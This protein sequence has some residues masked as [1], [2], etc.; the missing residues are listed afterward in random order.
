MHSHLN[1]QRHRWEPSY[2][3]NDDD[4]DEYEEEEKRRSSFE[5]QR[6]RPS[7]STA[8]TS[9]TATH[10]YPLYEEPSSYTS[11]Y[12]AEEDEDLYEHAPL[13]EKEWP[14]STRTRSPRHR[15]LRDNINEKTE[16]S[17]EDPESRGEDWTPSCTDSLRRQWQAIALS[18]RFSLFRT[19]RRLRRRLTR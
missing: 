1:N 8:Y 6:R 15:P 14:F 9:P 17:D 4:E 16:Q 12:L 13:K 19:K 3:D 18:L 5:T 10:S 2:T 7:S 11:R